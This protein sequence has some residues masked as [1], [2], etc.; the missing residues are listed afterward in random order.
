MVILKIFRRLKNN[1]DI[2]LLNS[3]KDFKNKIEMID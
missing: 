3:I 1:D 2:L